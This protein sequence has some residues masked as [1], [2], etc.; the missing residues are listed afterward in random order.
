VAV[1]AQNGQGLV[2]LPEGQALGDN[3]NII[4][5]GEPGSNSNYLDEYFRYYNGYGQPLNPATGN[6]GPNSLTH[7]GPDYQGP[8]LGYPGN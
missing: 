6:P 3:A 2:L 1:E 8:L 4:R 5:Y 7:F